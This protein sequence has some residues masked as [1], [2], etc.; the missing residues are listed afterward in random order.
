MSCHRNHHGADSIRSHPVNVTPS[1]SVPPD[2][3]LD[4]RGK[5]QCTTCHVFHGTYRDEDGKR[6]FYLRRS[7]GKTFCYSCHKK[8]SSAPARP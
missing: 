3:V 5:I 8:L 1:M 2:M 6:L 4:N 7:P